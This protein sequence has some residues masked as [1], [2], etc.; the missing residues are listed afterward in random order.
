MKKVGQ[1]L[2]TAILLIVVIFNYVYS[3]YVPVIASE[4]AAEILEDAINLL[5]NIL[6]G[7]IG[8]FTWIPRLIA[9]AIGAAIN[10]I[11]AQVA[12]MDS[13]TPG[14]KVSLDQRIFLTPF[15][16]FFNKAKILDVNFL[17]TDVGG[18]TG[19]VRTAVAKW[20][21][22]IRLIAIAILLFILLYV[23]I[24]MAIASVA[25]EKAVYKRALLDWSVSL[26]L[27][28]VLQYI[29]MFT[30]NANSAIVNALEITS[31]SDEVDKAIADIAFASLGISWTAMGSTVVYLIF[32]CQ[33]MGI[34]GKYI[35]RM[36]TI[37]FLIIISPLIS[38]TYSLDKMGDGKA[39]ALNTW[40]K[41]FIY[42]ILIQPF[43]C[44]MYMA[45]VNVAFELL[46]FEFTWKG[47]VGELFDNKLGQTIFAILCVK[48]ID[49]GEKIV[50]KIFGFGQASSL[51]PLE[52]AA[53]AAAVTQGG[54]MVVGAAQTARKGI[55]F[56][57]EK[58]V[59]AGIKKDIGNLKDRKKITEKQQKYMKENNMTKAAALARAK[60][61]AEQERENNN[62]ETM[63]KKADKK[64]QKRADRREGKIEE[65]L[66]KALSSKEFQE[67]MNKK[68]SDPDGYK[69]SEA[70][71]EAAKI[72]SQKENKGKNI[73]GFVGNVWNSETG[74]YI[75]KTSVPLG[76]GIA[77]GGLTYGGTNLFAAI[78]TGTAG[79]KGGKEFSNSSTKTMATESLNY[80]E[81]RVSSR[82]E[83]ERYM[84][85]VQQKGENG[86]YENKSEETK[87]LIKQLEALLIALGEYDKADQILGN[88][89]RD[90]YAEPDKFDLNA[91]LEKAVGKDKAQNEELQEAAQKYADHKND[92]YLYKQIQNADSMGVSID[93]LTEEIDNRIDY[94]MADAVESSEE[95]VEK[96][97]PEQPSREENKN[98]NVEEI[99]NQ[100]D[101]ADLERLEQLSEIIE[102]NLKQRMKEYEKLEE[103]SR[104]D[105]TKT[106]N[107]LKTAKLEITRKI[108]ELKESDP[109]Y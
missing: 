26:A 108:S 104:A 28:F 2:I 109:N 69:N 99:I 27:V 34:L 56:A 64:R 24:R 45:F 77:L 15:E 9:L 95:Y 19:T 14:K 39:Q 16:I 42:N 32:V 5:V 93:T 94:S 74:K 48:F 81:G 80:T 70:Y 63:K 65:Q 79:Y 30:V 37:G 61:E 106:I 107:D 8:I 20:Y 78:G 25:S 31:K 6:G 43:H 59:V 53:T 44:V 103:S 22:I 23:G 57:K 40:L 67:M 7:V 18:I 85:K 86:A 72:V 98:I 87:D 82:D 36:L 105:M 33:T 97:K 83:L 47:I 89:S 13:T 46:T 50:R 11:T 35:K 29:I 4:T 75:R 102:N 71:K 84:Q 38:I 54:K 17:D 76:I 100:V 62:K 51:S 73:K 101:S 90:L 49:D 52:T 10:I 1:K 66:K 21:Y 55:N 3:N 92:G 41:E 58:G 88:I 60:R 12:Y 68:Q 91:I 96:Q